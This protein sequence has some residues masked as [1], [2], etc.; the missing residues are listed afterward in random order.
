MNRGLKRM[1]K[2]VHDDRSIVI[3]PRAGRPIR[4]LMLAGPV[5]CFVGALATDIT[6]A[7]TAEMMWADF[8]AWLLAA[9]MVIAALAIIVWGL[10]LFLDRRGRSS[11]PGWPVVAGTV[12][13]LVLG[14]LDN[15]VHSRDAWTS[16]VPSGLT[17]SALTVLA[18]LVTIWL[19]A[20]SSVRS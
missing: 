17:L 2:L 20:G 13:V 15:L 19:E 3:A 12:L 11:W 5:A 16:V 6:Y 7:S 1:D 10:G 8:S 14:L 9:A 18:M 4:L